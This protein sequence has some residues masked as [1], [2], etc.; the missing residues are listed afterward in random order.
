MLIKFIIIYS[1]DVNV[2][3]TKVTCCCLV[4]KY[5]KTVTTPKLI[6]TKNMFAITVFPC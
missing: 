3:R 6:N 1:V 4:I 5:I 2:Q